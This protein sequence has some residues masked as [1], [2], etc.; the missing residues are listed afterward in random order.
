M[1]RQPPSHIAKSSVANFF[2]VGFVATVSG[3]LYVDRGSSDDKKK[4]FEKIKQRQI[5]SE[6]GVYP[7]LIIYPEGGTSNGTTLLQFKKGAFHSLRSI[8]PICIKYTSQDFDIESCL[9]NFYA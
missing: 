2:F 6:N 1:M 7:P 8:Q 9:I 3:C 4:M 5:E